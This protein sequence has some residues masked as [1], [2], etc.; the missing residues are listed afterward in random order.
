M[1]C[2]KST[3]SNK[4]MEI[5]LNKIDLVGIDEAGRG[6][7]AG[8][9]VVA[10]VKLKNHIDGLADSKKLS[11]KKRQLLYDKIINN[12][13]YHICII[14]AKI[15]DRDGLSLCIKN[16]LISI[17][18]NINSN[19]YL[20]DGNSSYGIDGLE[21]LIK[22]DNTID[23]VKAASIVAKVTKN[24]ELLKLGKNYPEYDFSSHQGYLTK[25]HISEI[26]KY[27]F[28][29]IHRKSYKIKSI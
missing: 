7:G 8:P 27:G 5:L 18:Q 21:H 14:D 12:S 24:S 20:F 10:G 2:K 16:A 15:I 25:K 3:T 1:I 6:C 23:E 28:S 4:L 29:P 9:L 22:A 19:R 26:K 11:D 13:I 17:M